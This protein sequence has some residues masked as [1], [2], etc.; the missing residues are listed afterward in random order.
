MKNRLNWISGAGL[1]TG[2]M[3]FFDPDSGRRRRARMR[4]QFDHLSRLTAEAVNVT[5]R[6]LMNRTRGVGM[7]VRH[8]LTSETVDDRVLAERVRSALGG[9]VSHPGSI[10]VDAHD[11]HVILSGVILADEV[12]PLLKRIKAVRGVSDV[13]DHLEVHQEPGNVPGLQGQPARRLAGNQ[14]ELMQ[15]NWSPSARLFAGIAGGALVM[16]GLGRRDK[17]GASVSTAGVALF[18]RA[19]TNMELQRL[20]GV[21]DAGDGIHIQKTIRIHAPVEDVF[22]VLSNCENFPKFMTHIREVRRISDRRFHWVVRGLGGITVEWDSV[23][24][25][26]VPNET[27]AWRSEQ[28]SSV[29]QTGTI[30]LFPEHD[31]STTVDIKMMYHPPAGAIGHAI[32]SILGEDPETKMN[33]DLMRFKSFMETGIP[34]HDASRKMDEMHEAAGTNV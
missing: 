23:F 24:T 5:I 12:G 34:P 15:S 16:Y 21:G 1:A 14:F 11:G 19:L 9:V 18:V 10:H 28:G 2:L 3:Y 6:D 17:Y 26:L 8:L 13:E 25:S 4:D 30:R 29:G 7:E 20:L 33:D 32:A 31:G 27:I 22:Q